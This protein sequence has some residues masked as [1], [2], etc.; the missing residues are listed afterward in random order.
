MHELARHIG[1]NTDVPA[2]DIGTGGREIGYMFG[3]YKKLR[4][5]FAGILTGK[6]AT[7][8][9]S[10]MRPEATGYGLVY[11]VSEML[12]ELDGSDWKGKK[13]LISGAGNVA[14][15]AA[16]LVIQYGGHVV[17]LSDSTGCLIAKD[18]S[19]GFTA[20]EVV[21]IQTLK[22]QRK[23]L[24]AF[25]A[26]DK[27]TWHEGKRPWTL[28]D[29]VDIALPS[30]SQNEINGDEAK[31]L[32]KAGCR[33][34]AEGSNMGCTQEAIDVFEDSRKKASSKSDA[35]VWYAPGKAANAGGVATSGI[36]MMQNSAREQWS[37]DV[38]DQKLKDIMVNIYKQCE[39][40][41]A[42]FGA[43][44]AAPSLVTGANIA[45]FQRVADAM[46]AQ[47]DWF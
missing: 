10:F 6:G 32:L 27:F 17:S 34:V 29:K 47:G 16:L 18:S 7:W 12:R 37:S 44:G 45:G 3:A 23:S 42:E 4:N 46:R 26:T 43:K 39:E 11:Y 24:T 41:G 40:T 5:E 35:F 38:V 36:E 33:Y 9:G 2:G 15:Y 20:D 30:A 28:V 1:D 25:D 13:V 8:G 22:D 14:Q 19:K 21:A 31:A